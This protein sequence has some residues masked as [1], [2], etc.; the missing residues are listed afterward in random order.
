MA[1]ANG[2]GVTSNTQSRRFQSGAHGTGRSDLYASKASLRRL[3]IEEG[4]RGLPPRSP[5][6]DSRPTAIAGRSRDSG[7]SGRRAPQES[8]AVGSTAPYGSLGRHVG[9]S[10]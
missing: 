1:L 6:R 7:G 5:I 3:P 10:P 2:R 9:V 8:G 4:L